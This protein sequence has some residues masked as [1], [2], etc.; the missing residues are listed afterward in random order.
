MGRGPPSVLGVSGNYPR[1]TFRGPR[2]SALAPVHTA[3]VFVFNSRVLTGRTF[4]RFGEAALA[5]PVGAELGIKSWY[6]ML[7]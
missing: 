3:A 4:T 5:W 1:F 7:S 6:F 2:A